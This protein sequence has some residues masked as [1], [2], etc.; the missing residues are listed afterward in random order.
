MSAHMS[1]TPIC[2][3]EYFQRVMLINIAAMPL[4][5]YA[6]KTEARLCHHKKYLRTSPCWNSYNMMFTSD[7][8]KQAFPSSQVFTHEPGGKER[9]QVVPVTG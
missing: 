4:K 3:A 7:F 6:S 8:S 2:G 5:V 1:V 9:F